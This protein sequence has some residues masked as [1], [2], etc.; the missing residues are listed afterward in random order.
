MLGADACAPQTAV[1]TSNPGAATVSDASQQ[2]YTRLYSSWNSRF[3]ES[4]EKVLHSAAELAPVWRAINGDS[5]APVPA[6]DFTRQMVVFIALGQR[7]S[8]GYSLK[9]DGMSATSGG[10]VV[11][12]T[13][14]SPG[15]GCM[16]A[17]VLSSPV[18]MVAVPRTAGTVTFERRDVVQSC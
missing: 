1:S 10:S 12:Y 9:F 7:M 2:A 11:R 6:V 8:G 5:A 3:P 16:N 4:A 15:P 17:Q 14:T 18:E 13:A